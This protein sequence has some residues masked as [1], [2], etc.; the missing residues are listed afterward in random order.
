MSASGAIGIS[1]FC[2]LAG[3][4]L[5]AT[6]SFIALLYFSAL[7]LCLLLYSYSFSKMLV[8]SN[9]VVAIL[10]CSVFP[11][12]GLISEEVGNRWPLLVA[13]TVFSLLHHFAREI[14]KDL[15]DVDGDAR[16]GRRTIPLV[17]GERK[18]TMISGVTILLL[19]FS[20]YLFYFLLAA[21]LY[22][23]LLVTLGVNMPLILLV[24]SM[25][26]NQRTPSR[27]SSLAKLTILPGLAAL[28]V[29]G[30]N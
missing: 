13:A 7:A 12:A 18:A 5:A 9:A 24:W 6:T 20:T 8:I 17:W 19:V 27:V 10:C 29:C 30:V 28:V 26:R 14:I 22:F 11:F 3:V 21:N 25:L 16:I 4:T 15:A 1:L 2:V 23:L